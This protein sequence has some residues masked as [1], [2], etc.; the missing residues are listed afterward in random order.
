M[1][2]NIKVNKEIVKEGSGLTVTWDVFKSRCR[3]ISIRWI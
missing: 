1:Y 3:G 2:L